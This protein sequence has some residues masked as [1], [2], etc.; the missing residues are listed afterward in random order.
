MNNPN[1]SIIIPTYNT[2]GILVN[3]LDS[4]LAQTLKDFEVLIID[5]KSQDNTISII[6]KYAEKDS[7]VKWFSEKD[8]GIYDAMNKGISRAKGSW[9]LFFGSDDSFYDKKVLSQVNEAINIKK[10]LRF[11][12]G[13][14]KPYSI[15]NKDASFSIHAGEFDGNKLIR[16]NICHQAI[17]YHKSLFT[18]FGLFKREYKIFADYDFNLRC[19]NKVQ[20]EYIDLIIANFNVEGHSH[21]HQNI[22]QLFRQTFVEN[23]AVRYAYNFKDSF[24]DGRKKELFSLMLKNL[25]S[26]KIKEPF[27]IGRILAYQSVKRKKH[28]NIPTNPAHQTI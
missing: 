10:N 25:R 21:K 22:D 7:R 12:Y 5:G 13:N 1:F 4:I 24:F 23:M 15:R 14:V 8:N 17:F 9:L 11:L 16:M 18:L 2:E 3:A 20:P 26:F 6:K 19:F 27:K 28:S